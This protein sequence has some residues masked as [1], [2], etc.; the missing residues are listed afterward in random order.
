MQWH[1][2][3]EEGVV[4]GFEETSSHHFFKGFLFC[5]LHEI[6]PC[7]ESM[8]LLGVK[9]YFKVNKGNGGISTII[10]MPK[11]INLIHFFKLCELLEKIL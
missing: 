9:A 8:H 1:I 3:V 2:V 11:P 6:G 7:K 5:A 10:P 4:V